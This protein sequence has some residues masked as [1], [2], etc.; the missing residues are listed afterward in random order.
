MISMSS[1]GG[2]CFAPPP[3]PRGSARSSVAKLFMA[4]DPFNDDVLRIVLSEFDKIWK[5]HTRD[6]D[7]WSCVKGM[8]V[9][10]MSAEPSRRESS[11]T[12]HDIII[13]IKMKVWID[14][15]DS[16]STRKNTVHHRKVVGALRVSPA[17]TRLTVDRRLQ[18]ELCFCS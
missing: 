10:I 7:L 15:K 3:S 2:V 5:E 11:V 13:C 14:R 1:R 18:V 12:Y 4:R 16:E 17:V 6:I 9:I 8:L